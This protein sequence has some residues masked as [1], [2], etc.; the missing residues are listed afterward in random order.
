MIR[1]LR[2]STLAD[3]VNLVFPPLSAVLPSRPTLLVASSRAPQANENNCD[4]PS[5]P[6]E[7]DLHACSGLH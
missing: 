2:L 4:V 1:H 6:L 5:S 7:L 3:V